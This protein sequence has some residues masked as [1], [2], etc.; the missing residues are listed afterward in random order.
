MTTENTDAGIRIL[1]RT[2]RKL[3]ERLAES[4][5]LAAERVAELHDANTTVQLLSREL[6]DVRTR[7]DRALAL[8]PASPADPVIFSPIEQARRILRGEP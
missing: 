1:T 5:A 6:A 8:L 3:T 4:D 7:M 2:I